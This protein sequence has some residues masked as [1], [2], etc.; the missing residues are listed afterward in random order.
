MSSLSLHSLPTPATVIPE[1]ELEPLTVSLATTSRLLGVSD[2][3]IRSH[4]AE[5]PH[6][7]LGARLL[8][9]MDSLRRFLAEKEQSANG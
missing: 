5:I 3:H 4:L 7:R 8:F 6:V 2:R 9:R 1:S